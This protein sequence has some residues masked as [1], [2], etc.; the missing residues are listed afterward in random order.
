M[1]KLAMA[2]LA[3]IAM[4]SAQAQ[5]QDPATPESK[6]Y[7][8][9]AGGATHLNAECVNGVSCKTSSTG[10]KAGAG[11]NVARNLSVEA[12]NLSLGSAKASAATGVVS[13]PIVNLDLKT[14]AWYV[15][16]VWTP[17]SAGNMM[18]DVKL[19][20]ASVKTTATVTAGS[21]GSAAASERKA[22]VY[23]GADLGFKVNPNLTILLGV[24]VTETELGGN[25]Y[26][27]SMLSLG[28]KFAF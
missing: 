17:P 1:K 28:A 4:A 11:W 21:L 23:A 19:G 18:W 24:D 15:A 3:L 20:V 6:A 8:V 5:S 2:A 22:K 14:E 16:G 26:G 13:A 9:V 7:L 12:G 10:F 25:K 27:A